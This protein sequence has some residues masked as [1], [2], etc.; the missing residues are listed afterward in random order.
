M[1]FKNFKIRY[2]LTPPPETFDKIRLILKIP[3]Y[4][5][6]F[7]AEGEV[8]LGYNGQYCHPLVQRRE[9]LTGT[10]TAAAVCAAPATLTTRW[11]Q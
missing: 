9:T 8:C 1:L 7:L 4:C 6:Q 2:P 10:E 11:S 3:G 5:P